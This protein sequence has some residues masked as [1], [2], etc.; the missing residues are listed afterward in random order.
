MR[1]GKFEHACAC[2][3]RYENKYYVHFQ[4][5][6]N[7]YIYSI[8]TGRQGKLTH[9]RNIMSQ[10]RLHTLTSHHQHFSQV[11]PTNHEACMP[12]RAVQL[13]HYFVEI[14]IWGEGGH[15]SQF[16]LPTHST[17]IAMKE[18]AAYGG[19]TEHSGMEDVYDNPQ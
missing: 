10:W 1:L 8:F 11:I 3:C 2:F 17:D 7:C 5:S 13:K 16:H 15:I 14:E 6:A 12:P 19:V 9:K 18:C 4:F